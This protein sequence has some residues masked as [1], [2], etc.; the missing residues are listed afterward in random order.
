[1]PQIYIYNPIHIAHIF[2]YYSHDEKK[3]KTLAQK[4]KF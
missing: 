4:D 3:K 2:K 1:M